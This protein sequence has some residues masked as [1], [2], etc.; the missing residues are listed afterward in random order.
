[1]RAGPRPG[2]GVRVYPWLLG[3]LRGGAGLTSPRRGRFQSSES[4][5]RRRGLGKGFDSVHARRDL[6]GTAQ[7]LRPD[8]RRPPPASLAPRARAASMETRERPQ[9]RSGTSSCRGTVGGRRG[10]E[11]RRGADGG[12]GAPPRRLQAGCPSRV[13]PRP[14]RPG[15]RAPRARECEVAPGRVARTAGGPSGTISY[16]LARLAL[17]AR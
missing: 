17:A 6:W 8:R 15:G 11:P 2:V 14:T 13:D 7:G 9:G 5:R 1:M 10:G 12:R 3:V 4:P 16:P